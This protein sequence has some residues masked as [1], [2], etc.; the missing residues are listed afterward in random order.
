MFEVRVATEKDRFNLYFVLAP[1]LVGNVPMSDTSSI[2]VRKLLNRIK[3]SIRAG[4]A[5]LLLYNDEPIGGYLLETVEGRRY[6]VNANVLPK[7]RST[8]GSVLIIDYIL[9]V[10]YQGEDVYIC[11]SPDSIKNITETRSSRG[12]KVKA[13]IAE[14]VAKAVKHL[15][16]EK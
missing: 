3:S 2:K 8:F 12:N 15:S 11:G 6:I 5:V 13:G 1:V 9:N 14:R 16:K 7:F 10:I 4:E